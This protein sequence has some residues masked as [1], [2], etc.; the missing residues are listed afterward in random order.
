MK[1]RPCAAFLALAIASGGL[2]APGVF[3]GDAAANI[4]YGDADCDG[5]VKMNDA[6]LIMQC[7]SNPDKYSLTAPG[8]ANADVS[9]RYDGITPADALAVQRYLL[10]M[11]ELPSGRKELSAE[12]M[13][14]LFANSLFGWLG[15]SRE[16]NGGTP[17]VLVPEGE[18]YCKKRAELLSENFSAYRSDADSK[19]AAVEEAFGGEFYDS[20][21]MFMEMSGRPYVK[22]I[23]LE[24]AGDITEIDVVEL[25][26]RS[27]KLITDDPGLSG[28]LYSDIVAGGAV[29]ARLNAGE[30]RMYFAVFLAAKN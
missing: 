1:R 23:D 4:I 17:L 27:A 15:W 6:V 25:A 7:L 30:G 29:G 22:E 12:E 28:A 18:I 11:G 3:A 9:G 14:S 16:Q 5:E 13:E 26:R 10:H 8:R 2:A 19:Q 20:Y 21:D 24:G